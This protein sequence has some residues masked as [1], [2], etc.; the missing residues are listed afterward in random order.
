MK[1]H[2]DPR[3]NLYHAVW[4]YTVSNDF[5]LRRWAHKQ[6]ILEFNEATAAICIAR[7]KG[8]RIPTM[9]EANAYMNWE[10]N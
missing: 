10:I 3:I 8:Q 6:T 4:F 7:R 5:V 9:Q 2:H 1:W